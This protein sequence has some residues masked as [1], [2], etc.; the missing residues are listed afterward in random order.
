MKKRFYM[1]AG[2]IMAFAV[3][4]G[5]VTCVD[6]RAVGPQ[7]STVGFGT[8][9]RWFHELT[10]VHMWIYTVTDW[11]GLVPVGVGFGFAICGLAQW[12]KRKSL[13]KVD[14]SILLLG[15]FYLAVLAVYVLFEYVV[16]NR[17]PVLID[18]ILEVSYP[19]STTLLVLCVMPTAMLRFRSRIRNKTLQRLISGVIVVF[20]GFMVVGRLISGVHWLTDIIGGILIS[21]GL[22]MLYC[23]CTKKDGFVHS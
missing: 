8:V 18:G 21:T 15:G 14:S 4:S 1:A 13:R 20:I 9:N 17:R 6:V 5:L 3:W 11:L 2:L 12:I 7:G 23:G 16:I 10:G 22:V 19:S